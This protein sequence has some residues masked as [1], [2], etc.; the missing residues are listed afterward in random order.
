MGCARSAAESNKQYKDEP[1]ASAIRV[2]SPSEQKSAIQAMQTAASGHTP[3]RSPQPAVH[4]MRWSD[5]PNAVAYAL[6]EVEM[7]VVS[8]TEHDWG[9]EF[10]IL[11]VEDDPGTL[12]VKRTNDARV[13]EAS[14]SIGRIIDQPERA[15]ALLE[16]LHKQML[17]F[18]RKRTL[19]P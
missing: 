11:S 8:G 18:G 14:A 10:R 19:A 2:L 12:W 9:W 5:V 7:A 3:V 13:Y 15:K 17:A 16:E 6:D 1:D 4:G